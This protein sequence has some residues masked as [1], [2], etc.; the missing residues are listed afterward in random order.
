[1]NESGTDKPGIVLAYV[2]QC[3]LAL[4]IFAGLL[5]GCAA[6]SQF[7]GAST[8]SEAQRLNAEARAM[9]ENGEYAHALELLMEALAMEPDPAVARRAAHLASAVEDW[10]TA[11]GAA[12]TWLE[13]SP[14]ASQARQ[15]ATVAAFRQGSVERGIELL[16]DGLDDEA[17][18]MDWT[19][20]VALLAAS[21]SDE[22][23]NS[24]LER[25]IDQAL[26]RRIRGLIGS[27]RGQQR[28]GRRPVHGKRFIVK[29]VL[30]QLDAALDRPLAKRGN[31]RD[32]SGL[33][34]AWRQFQPCFSRPGR[35]RPVFD[36]RRQM[37]GSASHGGIRLHCKGF[38]Q[39]LQ[40]M[41]IF[42]VLGHGTR[43]GVES[44]GLGLRRGAR[45]LRSGCT[46]DQQSGEYHQR[47]LAL[48]HIS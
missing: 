13:L 39:Q 47:Q 30:K 26:Q 19:T 45:E 42:T 17:F 18:P 41:G 38:H 36:G 34:C 48:L 4:V 20:A 31:R 40:G 29:P 5:I 2:K 10:P 28:N 27:G 21:G 12:E 43:L 9:A 22:T 11:A 24:A 23:A 7:P 46:T 16:Q 32:L 6:G 37:R 1:M 33:A 14:G 3:K 8:Q 44:L 25:L 35:G 15:I